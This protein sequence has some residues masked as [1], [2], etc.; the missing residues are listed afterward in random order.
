MLPCSRASTMAAA[1]LG[2]FAPVTGFVVGTWI[3]T[4]AWRIRILTLC[5]M[6]LALAEPGMKG[7]LSAEDWAEIR[8]LHRAEQ[9]PVKAIARAPG[10]SRNTVRRRS[11]VTGRRSTSA[12]RPGRSWMRLSRGSASC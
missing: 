6:T 1:A 11:R 3:L 12:S 2:E 4:P 10:I 7:V 8:R 5:P 9:M